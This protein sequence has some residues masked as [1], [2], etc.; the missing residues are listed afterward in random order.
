M[1]V[2][3]ST[4]IDIAREV[5]FKHKVIARH[6]AGGN[7]VPPLD[8]VPLSAAEF[9]AASQP[10]GLI[11]NGID[12]A[13]AP[14]GV[15]TIAIVTAINSA[16][17]TAFAPDG[18]ATIGIATAINAAVPAAINSAFE[19]AF[20]PNGVATIGIATAINAAIPAAINSAVPAAINSAFET[21]FAHAGV[22]TNGIAAAFE[23][24]FAPDGVFTN[25][26]AAGTR[27]TKL[28]MRNQA[29]RKANAMHDAAVNLPYVETPG[30]NQGTTPTMEELGF[31]IG[32]APLTRVQ[33]AVLLVAQ[34]DVIYDMYHEVSFRRGLSEANRRRALE[35]FI[36]GLG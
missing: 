30:P 34:I 26:I 19:T 21:A 11:T 7:V 25:A 18:V 15:A 4:E 23:T 32:S 2:P 24:A 16:F 13:Y 3:V 5:V 14:Q 20:A 9:H 6:I 17:E 28:F 31:G 22:G 10:G 12:A 8:N 29:R 27:A 35:L 33:T 36:F 1:L